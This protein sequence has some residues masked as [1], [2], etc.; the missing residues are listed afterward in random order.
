MWD[1][2]TYEEIQPRTRPIVI[3]LVY[4]KETPYFVKSFKTIGEASDYAKRMF[5]KK[6]ED[7]SK[8]R[9]S[10]EYVY[11]DEYNPDGVVYNVSEADFEPGD[12]VLNLAAVCLSYPTLFY[13]MQGKY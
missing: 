3:P 10:R 5:V 6:V 9:K 7:Q 12:F 13:V 4:G 11:M 1:L 2:Y 8:L